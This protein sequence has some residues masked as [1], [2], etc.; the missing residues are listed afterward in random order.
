M[1]TALHE[2]AGC[3]PVHRRIVK[4]MASDGWL[5]IGW[6]TEYGGQGRSPIEQFIFFDESMRSGAPVPD[7]H[8]Q[9]RGPDH[10]AVRQP[11]AEGLLPAQDPRRRDLTSA[12][13]TPSPAPA[14]T[15]PP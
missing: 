13:A 5:G 12:S 15:W 10:H 3:G 11:G 6:P 4:Q 9:H 2:E 1:R 14:P 7:A 8:H